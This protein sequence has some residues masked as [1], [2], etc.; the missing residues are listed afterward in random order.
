MFDFK[1][2]LSN[3]GDDVALLLSNV[4]VTEIG[5]VLPG[6]YVNVSESGTLATVKLPLYPLF[7][8][9]TVFVVSVAFFIVTKSPTFKLCGSSAT[10][11]TDEDPF[12]VHVAMN[13]GFLSKKKSSL[14]S[15]VSLDFKVRSISVRIPVLE[16]SCIIKLLSGFFEFVSSLGIVT[17]SL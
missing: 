17:R 10:I 13:L 11:L 7:A 5:I 8:A 15:S 16:D 14:V 6:L 2:V 1:S 9:P 12:E 3:L 4:F